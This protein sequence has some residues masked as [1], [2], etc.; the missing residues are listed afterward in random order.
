[1]QALCNSFGFGIGQFVGN[2]GFLI[3]ESVKFSNEYIR[4][5]FNL[6]PQKHGIVTLESKKIIFLILIDLVRIFSNCFK[7]IAI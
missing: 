2:A 5:F 1:M 6:S 4:P 7:F 3:F